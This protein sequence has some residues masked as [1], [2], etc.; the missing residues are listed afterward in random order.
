MAERFSYSGHLP[1]NHV[2]KKIYPLLIHE[3]DYIKMSP[4][5][6]LSYFF[7]S[8][9]NALYLFMFLKKGLHLHFKGRFT[10]PILSQIMNI[11]GI[12]FEHIVNS[13]SRKDNPYEN[14]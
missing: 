13:K 2:F 6:R 9:L 10:L 11:Q 1:F 14:I 8:L 5:L 4:N 7:L 12:W 3:A